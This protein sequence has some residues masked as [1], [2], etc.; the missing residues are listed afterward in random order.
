MVLE[1]ETYF[2]SLTCCLLSDR[3]SVIHLQVESGTLSWESLSCSRAEVHKQDPGVGSCGVQV[4]EN[5]VKGHVYC[6]VYRP[7][8]SVG[9][10]QGVQERVSDGCE[11][12]QHKALKCLHHY[13]GQGDGS[14]II[15]SS[16]L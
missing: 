16:D 8:G 5:E 13:R 11:V 12:K 15:E 1:S 2:P 6:I 4:L 10:L 3:K 7:V 14:V 9:K